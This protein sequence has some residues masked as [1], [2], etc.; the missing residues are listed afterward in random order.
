M[1]G[2]G[3]YGFMKHNIALLIIVL[4]ILSPIS[5]VY[6]ADITQNTD[7]NTNISIDNG[8]KTIYVTSNGTDTN[9][10]LTNITPK[11]TISNA[12]NT[13]N[14]GDTIILGPGTYKE[15]LNIT[16]NITLTGIQQENIIID[17]QKKDSC[18]NIPWNHN[19]NH[20]YHHKKRKNR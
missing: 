6:A 14:N 8:S 4:M 16:K 12:I 10:G 3:G 1:N 9:T 5:I 17:G 13:S 7:K 11:R 15:N 2:N 20:Q 19:H 18:I